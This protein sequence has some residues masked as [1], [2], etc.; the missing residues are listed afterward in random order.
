MRR[1]N[2]L[3]RALVE[4][5]FNEPKFRLVAAV[6]ERPCQSIRFDR[7]AHRGGRP[8]KMGPTKGSTG[9]WRCQAA[10]KCREPRSDSK[11]SPVARRS[12]A[13]TRGMKVTAWLS[14]RIVKS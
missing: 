11:T 4:L 14:V 2:S 9:A 7:A 3:N 8:L 10:T 12:Q 13:S 6:T 5:G 1:V